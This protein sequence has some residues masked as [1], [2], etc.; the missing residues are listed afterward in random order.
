M[1]DVAA[2]SRL[3]G[4]LLPTLKLAG[5][6]IVARSGVLIMMTVDTIMT[7]HAG[8]DE[9]AWFGIGLSPTIA[10]TL[11]GLGFLLGVSI[12]TSQADGAGEPERTGCIWKTGLRHAV[13][14]GA[15]FAVLCL[16]GEELLLLIGQSPQLSEGGGRVMAMLGYGM[17]AVLIFVTCSFYLEGLSRPLPGMLIMLAANIVNLGLNW[18]LIHGHAGLP[19]MGAEGAALAT[20]LARWMTAGAILVYVWWMPC[21]ARYG[22][23]TARPDPEIGRRIRRLGYPM[24]LAMFVEVAAF[25]AMTQMAGFLGND[26]T[27]G[28]QIAHNLVALVFMSAIGLGAATGVRV[29]NAVGR[30]DLA[31]V[32]GAAAA[33]VLL[34]V[35]VMAMFGSLFLLIPETLVA[36]YTP[37][38]AVAA[39]ALPALMVAGFMMVF[40][41]SQAVLINALRAT[42]DVWFPMT[43]QI[44]SFWILAAPVAWVLAFEYGF[45]TAGLM[46]GIFAGVVAATLLNGWRILRIVSGP[47]ARA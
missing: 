36:A 25:M 8:G 27:A 18:L 15:L 28:Y 20:T 31:G 43:T 6:V 21:R 47:I 23:R 19:G 33:G 9:L 17:P 14:L 16:F 37:Q 26:A 29:G 12:L 39:F 13:P 45:G 10:L 24:G 7:G 41:G 38:A 44:I 22:V 40:D 3:G 1:T 11:L 42:G 32:R 30:G 35:L 2:V 4:H 46:G 5:P 34:V